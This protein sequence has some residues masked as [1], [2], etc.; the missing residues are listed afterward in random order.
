MY[1]F[2]EYQWDRDNLKLF[3]NMINQHP[4]LYDTQHK[5]YGNFALRKIEYHK[6][7]QEVRRL[8]SKITMEVIRK[9]VRSLRNQYVREV[10]SLKRAYEKNE[11]YIPKLWCF[12]RLCKLYKEDLTPFY[13]NMDKVIEYT[14]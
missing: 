10:R 5:D 2:R 8:D 6:L 12:D 14:I 3:I 11:S 13:K 4:M 1:L 7:L 9:K